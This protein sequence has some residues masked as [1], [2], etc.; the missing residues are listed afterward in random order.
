MMTDQTLSQTSVDNTV[1]RDMPILQRIDWLMEH[2]RRHSVGFQSPESFLARSLHMAQHPT[3][4][5]ALSCMDGRI[6]ISVATGTPDGIIVPLRNLGGRFD[7]G[8]PHFGSV[9]AGHVRSMVEQ[10]R[11]T[12]ALITYHY[13]K[14]D[15][16]RGC[17]GF[18]Y[19]TDAACNH[20]FELKRQAVV[21]ILTAYG[22]V[23]KAVE[24]M[25]LGAYDFIIKTVDL[26]LV[27]PVVKRALEYLA[28]RRQVGNVAKDK[29]NP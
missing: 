24:A 29:A 27:E 3:A 4:V 20:T 26:Q 5:I 13:S 15:S 18:H 16:H 25:K 12:L 7:L 14:G 6:N 10:G 2:A 19:D 22:T 17:A 8:W 9:L 21:I 28:L 23:E 11:R 1:I